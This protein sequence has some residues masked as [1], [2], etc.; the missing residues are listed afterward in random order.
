MVFRKPKLLQKVMGIMMK[1]TVRFVDFWDNFNIHDNIISKVL[2]NIGGIIINEGEPDLLIFSCFGNKHLEFDTC[3]KIYCTGENDFP[4]FNFCDYAISYHDFTFHDR[5]LQ[6]PLFTLNGIDSLVHS[7]SRKQNIDINN[8]FHRQFCSI[9]VSN[10]FCA[11]PIRNQFW[12]KLNEY[13]VVASG[14]QYNNNIGI[15]VE[16]KLEFIKDY[17]FNIA[18]ENSMIDSYTTE[19]I[20]DSCIV[21]SVPIY[22]GNL[23]VSKDFN[24]DAF[25]NISDFDSF[26]RAIDYIIKVDND[27]FL[28]GNYISANLLEY[29]PYKDYLEILHNFFYN[30]IH[31]GKVFRSKY[32]RMGIINSAS[33]LE[34]RRGNSKYYRYSNKILDRL[35]SIS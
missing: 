17:K 22:W 34:Y 24:P 29:Y 25:I 6:L 1:I 23:L 11:D 27:P 21:N 15:P 19:K 30:I 16:N 31:N 12:E 35:S 8:L 5:H 7:L 13:K 14:G 9:V 10:N 4:N 26:E 18:F 28:Y 20:I 33:L 2:K 32:G 3:I